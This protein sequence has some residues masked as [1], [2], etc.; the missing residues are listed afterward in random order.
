MRTIYTVALI[1]IFMLASCNQADNA[2]QLN[3]EFF[4]SEFDPATAVHVSEI[5]QNIELTEDPSEKI[6]IRGTAVE[7]CQ[8]KGCWVTIQ[9]PDNETMRITFTDYGF[10][11]PK[12]LAGQEIVMEGKAWLNR[13]SVNTLR[14]YAEDAG[15][16]PEEV[17][18][19]TEPAIELYFEADGV[20]VAN[21]E[22]ADA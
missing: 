12:D 3:G 22:S 6:A 5:L 11:V 9:V 18:A 10:F 1:A 15:H 17:E 16:S 21:Y 14:H 4:G 19:I 13:T 8:S 20:F 2:N 7:V